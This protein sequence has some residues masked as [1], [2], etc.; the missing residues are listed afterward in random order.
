M[1]WLGRSFFRLRPNAVAAARNLAI[2]AP[3]SPVQ[4]LESPHRGTVIVRTKVAQHAGR[5]GGILPIESALLGAETAVCSLV[6]GNEK[7]LVAA[8]LGHALGM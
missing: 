2:M 1:V 3:S 6:E 8:N 4:C 5:L 7:L